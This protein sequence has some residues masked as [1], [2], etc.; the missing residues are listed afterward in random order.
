MS[1]IR[2]EYL[3]TIMESLVWIAFFT[4]VILSF[5]FYLRFRNKERIAL[6]EKGGSNGLLE[7]WKPSF[8]FPWIKISMLL[9][10]I[11]FG[12]FLYVF[13]RSI[14]YDRFTL[15]DSFNLLPSFILLFGGLGIVF[16]IHIERKQ[17][18]NNG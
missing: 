4:A 7:S 13:I 18:A 17:K 2:L 3:K 12:I 15:I 6:I 10:G 11:G 9:V 16:G 1:S 8:K 14:T 5:Y